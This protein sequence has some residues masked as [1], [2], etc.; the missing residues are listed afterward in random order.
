MKKPI[1]KQYVR[2][3]LKEHGMVRELTQT[4]SGSWPKDNKSKRKPKR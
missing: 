4:G 2:P 3:T 1:K